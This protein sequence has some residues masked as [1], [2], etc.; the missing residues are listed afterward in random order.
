MDKDTN[1]N[2]II[3]LVLSLCVFLAW[4]LLY[5]IPKQREMEAQRAAE[6]ARQQ[7]Q[8]QQ[9][10]QGQSTQPTLPQS[11]VAPPQPGSESSSEA[12]PAARRIA[13][14]TPSLSGS[15][16]LRGGRLDELSL[17]KYH[18]QVDPESPVI[19][20]LSPIGSPDPYYIEGGWLA[21]QGVKVPDAN[22][23]WQAAEDAKLGVDNPVTITWDN[24]AGIE[25]QRTISVDQDY[26]FTIEQTVKN[27]SA[28]PVT[29]FP[30][31]QV[32]RRGKPDVED[33][34]FLHEGLIGVLN[35]K[36]EEI[37]YGDL[38]EAP[39]TKVD[40]TGG[41]LGI[42]DKYWAVA[43]VPDQKRKVQARFG[44]YPEAGRDVFRAD[45]VDAQGIN[46]EPGASASTKSHIFA[47]A[48]VVELVDTY[49]ESPGINKF[50]LMIDWG[51]FYY[52]TKP[53]YFVLQFFQSMTGNFGIAI[54]LTT[55]L[56]KLL[57]FP[58][59]NKSYSSM[60]KMKKLQPEMEKPKERHGDDRQK[61]QMGMMELYKK[62]KVNPVSGCLPVLLQ[63]PVF[64][65]LYKVLYGTITMRHEPFFGWIKDLSA[66]DPTSIFNLFGLLPFDVPQFLLIGVWPLL[67]GITMFVQMQL[68]P[69]PTDP[70]QAKIF[71]WMPVVFTFLLATFPAGLVIYWAWNNFL[72]IIQQSIIMTRHGVKIELFQ[73][74]KRMFGRGTKKAEE[75]GS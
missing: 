9:A 36:L 19:K 72:S 53:M 16:N 67:M 26:M 30:Y 61:V 46:I 51:W 28:A 5:G 43:L 41:W 38:Q 20:L 14:E 15:L 45:Y 22:T 32:T 63:I 13:I 18:E 35:D 60:A 31:A 73:N 11:G 12:Q 2:L 1:K 44:D 52:I 65:A 10:D 50:S 37:D 54:L 7:Q 4:Q 74:L 47:G 48:K 49:E 6:Q 23:V 64:F 8:T 69:A 58:I 24:G 39:A 56:L 33:F 27:S 71:T 29:L 34:Y 75:E 3:A 25:F 68:N 55:V 70:M 59:A 66:P 17:L 57:F 21:A 42:T 62:E 40:T